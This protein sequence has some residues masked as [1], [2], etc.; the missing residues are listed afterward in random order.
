M[1]LSFVRRIWTEPTAHVI[2]MGFL[3]VMKL[4]KISQPLFSSSLEYYR[5]CFIKAF[6]SVS[7]FL[8]LC[9][10]YYSDW[11]TQ[12]VFLSGPMIIHFLFFY[13]VFIKLKFGANG[14]IY[15][16]WFL[17]QKT[18]RNNSTLPPAVLAL[19][20]YLLANHR[21]GTVCILH[22]FPFF[23]WQYSSS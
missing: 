20:L 12:R 14:H 21:Q 6:F 9:F 4:C 22:I 18:A 15:A 5:G 23:L 2:S 1:F 19:L 8:S 3:K 10:S 13:G 11:M 16:G 7:M 17:G